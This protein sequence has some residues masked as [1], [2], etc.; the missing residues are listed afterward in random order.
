M[1]KKLEQLL[2]KQAAL[3]KQINAEKARTKAKERKEDTRR[4]ILLGAFLQAKLE[5]NETYK[6][7]I[8]GELERYLG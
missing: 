2:Q 1:S 3:Q 5:E 8:M 4:K 6:M 7:Q